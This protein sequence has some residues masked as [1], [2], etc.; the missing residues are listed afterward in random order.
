MDL[1]ETLWHSA[2]VF[3]TD[4]RRW[5]NTERGVKV[6]MMINRPVDVSKKISTS[7]LVT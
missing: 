2:P 5:K 1:S 6:K 3:L 4:V 7:L